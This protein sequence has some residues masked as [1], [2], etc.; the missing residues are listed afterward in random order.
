[1]FDRSDLT[2]NGFS[3]VVTTMFEADIA[4]YLRE[5]IHDLSS[6]GRQRGLGA[7]NKV[8]QLHTGKNTVS[9]GCPISEDDMAGLFA[10]ER[11]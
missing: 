3:D 4:Q 10:T 5:S 6:Q 8:D 11:T 9:R 1:L 2:S 7:T